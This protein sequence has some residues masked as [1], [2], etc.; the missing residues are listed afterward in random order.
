M[1]SV[2]L[3]SR[4]TIRNDASRKNMMSISGMMTIRDRRFGIG[5]GILM[6]K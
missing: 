4:L 3:I 2:L 6:G 1:V 5:E